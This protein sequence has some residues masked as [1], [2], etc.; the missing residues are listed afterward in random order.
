MSIGMYHWLYRILEIYLSLHIV[1]TVWR[2]LCPSCILIPLTSW[3]NLH[4]YGTLKTCNWYETTQ[5]ATFHSFYYLYIYIFSN[6]LF[7]QMLFWWILISLG[8]RLNGHYDPQVIIT[9]RNW[10]PERQASCQRSQNEHFPLL[11]LHSYLRKS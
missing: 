3:Y 10:D 7:R 11:F 9:Q 6:K 1:L 5:Y 4:F 8:V 2:N